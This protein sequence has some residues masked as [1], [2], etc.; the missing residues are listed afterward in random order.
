M[1]PL[2]NQTAYPPAKYGANAVLGK[3]DNASCLYHVSP[4]SIA[5]DNKTIYYFGGNGDVQ[6][7]LSC[8]TNEDGIVL[9]R[10]YA[11]LWRAR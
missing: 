1:Q 3:V 11:W 4:T 9:P 6:R 2:S 8:K 10:Y 5:S 7:A